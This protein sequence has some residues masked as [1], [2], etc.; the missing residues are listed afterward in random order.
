MNMTLEMK[1]DKK[2]LAPPSL[3]VDGRCYALFGQDHVACRPNHRYWAP[4]NHN[5][6]MPKPHAGLAIP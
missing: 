5:A 6:E 2:M 1:K 3:P 4:R